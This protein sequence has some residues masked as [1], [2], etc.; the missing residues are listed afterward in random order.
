MAST[1]KGE[2]RTCDA[3]PVDQQAPQHAEQE[4]SGCRPKRKSPNPERG[5]RGGVQVEP[6]AALYWMNMRYELC[7]ELC[8]DGLTRLR[9]RYIV[10]SDHYGTLYPLEV[11]RREGFYVGKKNI[12]DWWLEQP[13]RRHAPGFRP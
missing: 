2:G 7:H 9:A 1:K 6:W 5:W 8:R 10:P 4:H 12:V 13:N 11:I 3:A